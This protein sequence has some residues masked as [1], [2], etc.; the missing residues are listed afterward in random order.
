MSP[1]MPRSNGRSRPELAI[2]CGV[3]AATLLGLCMG[4]LAIR[5]QGIYQAMVTLAV[6]Q[7]AYFAYLQAGFTHGEDGIQSVPRGVL[8][9][10]IDLRDDMSVYWISAAALLAVLAGLR[11]LL[12]SRF[13]MALV[14]IRD[15]E[16]RARSLGYRVGLFKHAAF[17]VSAACAGLAG[18]LNTMAF[19]LATLSGAHWHF[20]GEA[21]LMALIGGIGTL[22][23]PLIGAAVVVAMQ[24]LLA[25]FGAWVLV[26]QGLVFM[27]CVLLFRDGLVVR[28]L[29]LA[30]AFKSA[31]QARFAAPAGKVR[32]GGL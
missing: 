32:E 4:V 16:Q 20:S 19:Q 7:M 6:A 5:R 11:R 26:F 22:N 15:N 9:G 12:R 30:R 2:L 25:P 1:R 10:L 27:A 14:A 8:F 17:G 13:G 21:V 24:Q 18:S 23:G 29:T 31:V 3:G 28:G